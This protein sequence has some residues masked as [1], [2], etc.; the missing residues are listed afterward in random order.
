MEVKNLTVGEEGIHGKNLCN[1]PQVAT[2]NTAPE[3]LIVNILKRNRPILHMLRNL[4]PNETYALTH[5]TT[6]SHKNLHF[7][8]H[9]PQPIST[10]RGWKQWQHYTGWPPILVV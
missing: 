4:K 2:T 1:K 10:S 5:S 8:D 3:Q 9:E 7:H 6:R